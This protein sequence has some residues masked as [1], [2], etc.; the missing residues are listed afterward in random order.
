MPLTVTITAE[1]SGSV[2]ARGGDDLAEH[3]PDHAGFA[4]ISDWHGTRHRLATTM[5]REVQAAVASHAARMLRAARYTVELDP[6]LDTDARAQEPGHFLGDQVLALTDRIRGAESGA[7]L[8]D[9]LAPLLDP[10]HRVLERV[11]EAPEAAGEQVTDSTTRRTSSP[12]GSASPQ[13]SSAPRSP[14]CSARM[15]S[16]VTSP[17]G[18]SAQRRSRRR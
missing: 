8:A 4:D 10:E 6:A 18:W 9:A 15:K 5:D 7:E 17:P 13:S 14:N 2:V 11:R 12:T 16:C 1:P 3:L